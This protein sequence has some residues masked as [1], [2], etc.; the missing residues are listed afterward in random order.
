[1]RV[2]R[3]FNQSIR[4]SC[5]ISLQLFP[6][7]KKISLQA[8]PSKRQILGGKLNLGDPNFSKKL[9]TG[10]SNEKLIHGK[11]SSS[12]KSFKNQFLCYEDYIK[13]LQNVNGGSVLSS[14]NDLNDVVAGV[15]FEHLHKSCM[16]K[17]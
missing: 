5:D 2:Q 16:T 11:L 12:G 3:K 13:I 15:V 14:P 17:S 8:V 10:L 1:M 9:S 6:T 4:N 7:T